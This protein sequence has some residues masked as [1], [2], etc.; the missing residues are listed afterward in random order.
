MTYLYHQLVLLGNLL[1]LVISMI[2]NT[3]ILSWF[4]NTRGFNL[5]YN[6]VTKATLN[7]FGIRLLEDTPQYMSVQLVDT[8]LSYNVPLTTIYFHN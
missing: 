2:I 3:T 7:N 5:G 8:P 1:V 4:I 6:D